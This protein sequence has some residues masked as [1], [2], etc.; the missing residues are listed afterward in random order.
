M[1]LF[2]IIIVTLLV[3]IIAWI[4]WITGKPHQMK[5]LDEER[6]Q[7]LDHLLPTNA[8]DGNSIT[9]YTDLEAMFDTLMEDVAHAKDHVHMQFFKFEDDATGRQLANVMADRA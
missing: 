9:T 8:C 4:L 6:Q 1:R 7:Q 3:A 2:Y 5:A